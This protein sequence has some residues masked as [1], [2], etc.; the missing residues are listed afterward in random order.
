METVLV[1]GFSKLLEA[2]M[3]NPNFLLTCLFTWVV[4]E[5]IFYIDVVGKFINGYKKIVAITIGAIIGSL[6]IETSTLGFIAGAEEHQG[7][8]VYNF[9]RFISGG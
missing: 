4:C 1:P 7:A 6:I 5:A 9:H 8:G 2:Y 3:E